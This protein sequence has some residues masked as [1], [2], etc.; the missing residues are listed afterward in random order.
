M[1]R[2]SFLLIPALLTAT[3]ATTPDEARDA[4]VR[5]LVVVSETTDYTEDQRVL[6]G[7]I[8]IA[9]SN[10]LMELDTGNGSPQQSMIFM[11]ASNE[12][13]AIDHTRRSYIHLDEETVAQ[14][15]A[16]LGAATD[17]MSEA[18]RAM[19]EQLENMSAAERAALERSGMLDR[20]MAM[21]GGE[22]GAARPEYAGTEG[23]GQSPLGPCTWHHWKKQDVT[24]MSLCE[25]DR[26]VEGWR[27]GR[28]AFTAMTGFVR[29]LTGPLAEFVDT[30]FDLAAEIDNLPVLSRDFSD[31][32]TLRTETRVLSVGYEDVAETSWD[33]PEGYDR[34]DITGRN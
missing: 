18:R 20:M 3:A 1:R 24:V 33:V 4:A 28:D 32:G 23:S 5:A 30:P 22:P 6:R 17:Q 12:M 10:V 31:D 11:G 9:G 27:D 7:Q 34:Q 29:D 15:Q 2:A 25:A 19:E 21:A 26:T 16:Q 13:F 14:L 8:V